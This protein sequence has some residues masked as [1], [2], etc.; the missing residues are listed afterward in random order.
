MKQL[1]VKSYPLNKNMSSATFKTCLY[2]GKL[3]IVHKSKNKKFCSKAHRKHF[4]NALN[5]L[6]NQ[7]KL[8]IEQ[9]VLKQ[10]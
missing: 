4:F 3:F 2:C 8:N 10:T 1:T 7:T 5:D 9:I 6:S